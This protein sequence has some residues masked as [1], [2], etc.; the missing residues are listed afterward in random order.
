MKELKDITTDEDIKLLV[1]RFYDKL[2]QD[3]I[4]KPIFEHVVKEGLQEHLERIYDFWNSILIFTKKYKGDMNGKHLPLNISQEHFTIWLK[5]FNETVDEYF[6][7]EIASEAK[8][9]ALTMSRVMKAMK[10]IPL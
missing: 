9:R 10:G 5:Y 2:L 1:D 4:M 3:E 7:G 6:L 8:N